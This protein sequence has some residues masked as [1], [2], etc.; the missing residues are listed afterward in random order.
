MSSNDGIQGG[1][2]I[3]QSI[4]TSQPNELHELR[5]QLMHVDDRL[6]TLK[7]EA[8]ALLRRRAPIEARIR[9]IEDK[10]P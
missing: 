5:M 2:L 7:A 4:T 8:E 10:L 1:G 9:E 3:V 6:S